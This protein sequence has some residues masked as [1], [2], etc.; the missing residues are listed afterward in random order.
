MVEYTYIAPCLGD[1]GAPWRSALV[2][3]KKFLRIKYSQ[4]LSEKNR[5]MDKT[6]KKDSDREVEHLVNDLEK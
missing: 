2:R 1:Q 4:V 6:G 3:G 5:R